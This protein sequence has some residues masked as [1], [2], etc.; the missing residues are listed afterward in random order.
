MP[1]PLEAAQQAATGASST[2]SGFALAF[3][4]EV[5][6]EQRAARALTCALLSR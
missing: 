1:E 3:D 6:V 4:V 5:A 2:S